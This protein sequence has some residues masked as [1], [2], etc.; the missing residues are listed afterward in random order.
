LSFAHTYLAVAANLIK[1]YSAPQPFHLYIKK[2]FAANKKH[3]S[4]D[5]KTI[6]ALCYVYFRLGKA[7]EGQTPENKMLMGLCLCHPELMNDDWATLLQ[8][9]WSFANAEFVQATLPQKLEL[10][11]QNTDFSTEQL[12]PFPDRL[13]DL[14]DREGFLISPLHRPLVWLRVKKGRREKLEE[15]ITAD[16]TLQ[17]HPLLPNAIGLPQQ[18]N[19]EQLLGNRF[20]HLA[21]VQ[22]ASSQQ[23]V[24]FIA[25]KAGEKVWDCCC[26]AGGKS[27]MLRDAESK[28]DLYCSDMRPQILENLHERFKVSG[29]PR[30]YTAVKDIATSAGDSI[31]FENKSEFKTARANYFDTIIADVPCSGSGT[32]ARTPEQAYN[33]TAEQIAGFVAR[34][35]TIV[36]NALPYLKKGGKLYYITCSAFKDENEGQLPYFQE[37]GMDIEQQTTI[38]GY[39]NQADTMFVAC[40]VKTK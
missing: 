39:T 20:H 3:G 40:L 9:Q 6:A 11:K 7:F 10:L 26:G 27:L 36:T 12:F 8:A 34:Q 16:I 35:R 13:S 38:E 2:Y 24:T 25:L 15:L 1:G 5:R 4:R 32:W 28:L 29:L 18:T 33:F 14:K 21:E 19:V 37:L 22:D 30:P 31:I 17:N 23:T